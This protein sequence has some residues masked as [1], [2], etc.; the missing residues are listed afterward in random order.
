MNAGVYAMHPNQRV[1]DF[2]ETWV[3]SSTRHPND[4]IA[5]NNLFMVKYGVCY[6]HT[7][8]R[9]VQMHGMMAIYKH[10]HFFPGNSCIQESLGP[11]GHCDKR[12]LYLH[13]LCGV[14]WDNKAATWTKMS[15]WLVDEDLRPMYADGG[16]ANG[17][18][19]HLP[20]TDGELAWDTLSERID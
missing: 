4:Q 19:P 6:S 10:V 16:G 8:C 15:N 1:L 18:H 9:S 11:L 12:R 20:C 3:H 5:L 17:P 14:G 7:Q 13:Y 2:M